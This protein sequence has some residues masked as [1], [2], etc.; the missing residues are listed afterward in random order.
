MH[1][2]LLVFMG[3][4]VLS[5]RLARQVS[6][7][8]HKSRTP[9]SFEPPGPDFRHYSPLTSRQTMSPSC[10]GRNPLRTQGES[11]NETERA[12]VPDHR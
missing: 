10:P 5:Y 11:S 9:M 7:V 12:D 1:L 3:V 2:R 8:M 4:T 6:K